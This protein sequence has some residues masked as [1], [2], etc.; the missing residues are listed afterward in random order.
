[1]D[2][3]GTSKQQNIY[4][5]LEW[6]VNNHL[7]FNFVECDESKRYSNLAP[8]SRNI[9]MSNVVVSLTNKIKEELCLKFSKDEVYGLIFDGWFGLMD[10]LIIYWQCFIKIKMVHIISTWSSSTSVHN[11]SKS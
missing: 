2:R 4:A 7:P 9:L 8:I 1:M 3:Y 11:K 10:Y 5:W 6:I